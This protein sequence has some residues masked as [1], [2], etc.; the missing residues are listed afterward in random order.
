METQ[1]SSN[2]TRKRSRSPPQSDSEKRVKVADNSTA[3]EV[4]ET[5]YDKDDSVSLGDDNMQEDKEET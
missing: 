3:D 4:E 2:D 1:G 5:E